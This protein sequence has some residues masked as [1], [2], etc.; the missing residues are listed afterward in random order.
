MLRQRPSAERLSCSANLCGSLHLCGKRFRAPLGY[1]ARCNEDSWLRILMVVSLR[2]KPCCFGTA[3]LFLALLTAG[4]PVDSRVEN[5]RPP[6][7]DKDWRN[8]ST[9]DCGEVLTNSPWVANNRSGV[10]WD[11]MQIR[12]ALPVRLALARQ[13]LIERK[14]DRATPSRQNQLDEQVAKQLA[15]DFKDR[16]VVHYAYGQSPSD[17]NAKH[18][19]VPVGP[20]GVLITSDGRFIHSL[21]TVR[22][23]RHRSWSHEWE[24]FTLVFPR[25]Q[26]GLPIIKAHST[27]FSVGL[28]KREGLTFTMHGQLSFR[29]DKMEYRGK[30]VY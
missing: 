18:A 15:E 5:K 19:W 7:A 3:M 11:Q 13:F 30:V 20:D 12:S 17:E 2:L 6:W 8:W 29:L 25:T 4:V 9:E 14:Y 28:G 27:V 24:E 26:A 10:W 1:V 23:Q 21:Q 16:I 22:L